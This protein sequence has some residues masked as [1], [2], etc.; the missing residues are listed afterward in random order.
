MCWSGVHPHRLVLG[1]G[2]ADLQVRQDHAAARAAAV[3]AMRSS[4]RVSPWSG[5]TLALASSTGVPSAF[6]AHDPGVHRVLVAEARR[7]PVPL[8]PRPP[9]SEIVRP[10]GSRART[11]PWPQKSAEQRREQAEVCRP[12]DRAR[13]ASRAS[14]PSASSWIEV[15]PPYSW[16]ASICFGCRRG[17]HSERGVSKLIGV[18]FIGPECEAR[19]QAGPFRAASGLRALQSVLA[20]SNIREIGSHRGRQ[21]VCNGLSHS[22]R[23]A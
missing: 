1:A 2:H 13:R 17:P 6:S 18:A 14:P 11:S 23:T 20:N 5:P 8:H 3:L 19:D 4:S 15:W 16:S 12:L 22:T 10:R 7:R 9:C 21:L